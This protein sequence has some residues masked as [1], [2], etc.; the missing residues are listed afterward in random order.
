MTRLVLLLCCAGQFMVVLDVSI[1]NIALPDI[2]GDLRIANGSQEW[3][4]NAY[5]ITVA[6]FLLLGGRAGDLLGRRRVFLSGL[7]L[8]TAASLIGGLA[9]SGGILIVARAL[10]GLGGAVVAPATLSVPRHLHRPGPSA[11][12]GRGLVDDRR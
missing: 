4:V 9:S 12:C 11:P 3:V 6:G 10:Q 1:V 2:F 5:T 7:G 8:F